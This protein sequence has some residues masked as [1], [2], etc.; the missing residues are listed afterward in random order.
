MTGNVQGRGVDYWAEWTG[1]QQ[2][3]GW[4]GTAQ[5]QHLQVG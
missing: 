5:E 4:A 2:V 3:W 1:L